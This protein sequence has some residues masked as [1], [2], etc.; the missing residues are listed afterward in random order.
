MSP[1][2]PRSLKAF[3]QQ[4][5]ALLAAGQDEDAT[6]LAMR[7]VQLQETDETKAFFVD[8]VKVL[9][10][11]ARV[12]RRDRTRVA[13]EIRDVIARALRDAWATPQ[14]FFGIAKALLRA[15]PVIGP[16]VA[17]ATAAWPRRLSVDEL[18]TGPGLAHL[19]TDPLLS[20]MLGRSSVFDL[21]LERFLTSLRFALLDAVM[22]DRSRYNDGI[23]ELC[24]ALGRQCWINEYVFDV[25]ADELARAEELRNRITQAIKTNMAVSPAELG[26]LSAYFPLSSLPEV[27]LLK[28]SWPRHVAELLREQIQGPAEQVT[29][30]A[31]IP[32]I[33]PITDP[34]STEVR[35]QYE[36]NPFPRWVALPLDRPMPPFDEWMLRQFPFS[37]FRRLG[38]KAGLDILI[39]GCGT[40]QHSLFFTQAFPDAKILAVDLSLTSL[41]YAKQKTREMGVSN[42]EY[43]QADILE[44]GTLDRQFDV[45]SSVG[46]LHHTSDPERGWRTLLRLLQPDGCM[47]IGV[48][49][50][51]AH[52]YVKVVQAWLSERGFTTSVE[53]IR[54]ARQE[55]AAA[56]TANPLF[57]DAFGCMDFYTT[58][59]FRDLFRP[60]QML[61]FTIPKLRTFVIENNLEFLG[62]AKDEIRHQFRVRFSSQVET[63]L[64]L[65]DCFESENPNTFSEMYDFWIQ[66]K[67]RSRSAIEGEQ[68]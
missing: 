63:D 9:C 1:V 13:L 36:E 28:R 62:F 68:P 8:C 3:L 20:A 22:R 66:K 33:T 29:L 19:A 11:R 43:A 21:D 10:W 12:T 51:R 45:I 15:D 23:A 42:I 26:L 57:A 47:Q 56:S 53:S 40:G 49:S 58:S 54:R 24:C 52:R 14:E 6:E 55:L 35:K 46:V 25:T 18:A 34:I 67:P 37:I 32:T 60:T 64:G 31:T 39:A 59:E 48:Y 16:A 4:G 41:S 38:K 27:P 17:R 50:E 7:V 2:D 5:K 44:L 65:W 30:R 61:R